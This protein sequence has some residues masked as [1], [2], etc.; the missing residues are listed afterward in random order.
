MR[1]GYPP[2]EYTD[3]YGLF[4]KEVTLGKLSSG[5]GKVKYIEAPDAAA[6]VDE[7]NFKILGRVNR[8]INTGG[9][10]VHP[11]EIE[12]KLSSQLNDRFFIHSRP[13]EEL[14]EEVVLFIE[15]ENTV[16]YKQVYGANQE[17][18]H[19]LVKSPVK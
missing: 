13:H 9:I 1:Y 16:L 12:F 17:K 6:S 10:K 14:G 5:V 8:V 15:N 4:V 18:S 19:T 7:M 3:T 2:F 11:E